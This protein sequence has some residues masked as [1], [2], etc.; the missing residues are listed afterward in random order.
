[1]RGRKTGGRKKGT[2]NKATTEARVACAELVDDPTYRAKLRDRLLAAQLAPAVETMLW[3]YA[4]GKPVD[5]VRLDSQTHGTL[6]LVV[7]KP[8]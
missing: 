8:W 4:K 3:H 5:E 2:F 7:M 1:M 6:E